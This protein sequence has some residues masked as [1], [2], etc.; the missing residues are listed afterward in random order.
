MKDFQD[1]KQ[2]IRQIIE[3]IKKL[4]E[5]EITREIE[6]QEGKIKSYEKEIEIMKKEIQLFKCIYNLKTVAGKEFEL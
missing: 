4:D 1:E 2:D 5:K 6:A 3:M